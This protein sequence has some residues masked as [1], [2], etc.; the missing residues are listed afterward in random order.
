MCPIVPTLQCGF[1]RSNFSFA[2][3]QL[4]APSSSSKPNLL[5]R[6]CRTSRS[7]PRE[8]VVFQSAVPIEATLQTARTL[9]ETWPERLRSSDANSRN[10]SLCTEPIQETRTAFPYSNTLRPDPT[11]SANCRQLRTPPQTQP[12]G[13]SQPKISDQ[14]RTA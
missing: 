2:I 6:R 4:L 12:A 8:I 11:T 1:V 3:N 7:T 10:P 13:H 14:L 9:I 5:R